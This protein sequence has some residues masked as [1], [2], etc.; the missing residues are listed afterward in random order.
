M[1][2]FSL[3]ST[4]ISALAIFISVF[5][6]LH[7]EIW[8]RKIRKN[9]IKPIIYPNF[10]DCYTEGYVPQIIYRFENI[11]GENVQFYLKLKNIGKGRATNI[12]ISY[13]NDLC[14]VMAN[15]FPLTINMNEEYIFC[16]LV[17]NVSVDNE[18]YIDISYD[19]IDGNSY[20][21]LM[22]GIYLKMDGEYCPRMTNVSQGNAKR[23]NPSHSTSARYI[24]EEL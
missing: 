3:V 7:N 1:D 8:Q 12:N 24:E 11:F 4:I 6:I 13:T 19:D 21:K 17:E 15:T 16:I 2:L 20:C 18:F 23:K 22:E 10:V 5:G 14:Q 9:D